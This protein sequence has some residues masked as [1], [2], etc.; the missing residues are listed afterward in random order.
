MP[1]PIHFEIHSADPE[2]AIG[3]YEKLF[4]WE[5]SSYGGGDFDYWTIKTGEAPEPGID[6]GLMR[7]MSD[8]APADIPADTPVIAWVGTVGVDDIDSYLAKALELG[9]TEALPKGAVPGMGWVAY[10][11]DTEGNVVGMFQLDENAA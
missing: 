7:R 9:A 11:K 5:F 8:I 10:I 3:F 6:G 1:R 2:R 4:G